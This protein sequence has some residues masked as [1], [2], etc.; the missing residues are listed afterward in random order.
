[1]IHPG[2]PSASGAA[3]ATSADAGDV[4][5]ECDLS[6]GL[7]TVRVRAP[8]AITYSAATIS[9]LDVMDHASMMSL[10]INKLQRRFA[11]GLRVTG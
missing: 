7:V 6:T 3:A 10:E 9:V 2:N 8:L 4:K 11:A 1:M 5:F